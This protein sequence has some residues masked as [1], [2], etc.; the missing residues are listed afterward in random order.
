MPPF[1]WIREPT[2][3][4]QAFETQH[5][6]ALAGALF[7]WAASAVESLHYLDDIDRTYDDSHAVIGAHRPDVVDV[8]HA[9]WATGTCIT[10]LDLCAAGLGRS[11]CKHVGPRELDLTCFDSS[12]SHKWKLER[13][14]GWREQLPPLALQWV[15]GVCAD[16]GYNKVKEARNWLVHS[17]LLRH[18]AI[19]PGGPPQ[20]LKLGLET[21]GQ[22][23]VRHLVEVARDVATRHIVAFLDLL[24][25]V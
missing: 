3:V 7:A 22:M 24:P 14:L 11:F 8:A 6:N 21:T 20:R 9:R 12:H 5:K 4:I 2:G 10:A 19:V 17:R 25:R 13:I 1:T 23:E 16:A 15:D 18:Y